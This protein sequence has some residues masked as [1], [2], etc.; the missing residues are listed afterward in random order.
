VGVVVDDD[1]VS[2]SVLPN[3]EKVELTDAPIIIL[4][5]RLIFANYYQVLLIDV[6]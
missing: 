2:P 3:D 5:S 6:Y 4:P 1:G